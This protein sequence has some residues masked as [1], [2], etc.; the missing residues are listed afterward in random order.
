MS[1]PV[2]THTSGQEFSHERE[3]PAVGLRLEAWK[4]TVSWQ[5]DRLSRNYSY[6]RHGNNILSICHIRLP[7]SVAIVWLRKPI[8][9]QAKISTKFFSNYWDQAAGTDPSAAK[10]IVHSFYPTVDRTLNDSTKKM[11]IFITRTMSK[12]NFT[13]CNGLMYTWQYIDNT[14]YICN[15]VN[16]LCNKLNSIQYPSSLSRYQTPNRPKLCSAHFLLIII[17]TRGQLYE[18]YCLG[19]R[20]WMIMVFYTRFSFPYHQS[21]PQGNANAR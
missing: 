21:V 9:S 13:V 6:E 8:P 5:E 2:D 4:I 10:A 15:T 20:W 18:Q 17:D 16:R 14:E 11:N 3:S 7:T 1:K 12:L 19:F